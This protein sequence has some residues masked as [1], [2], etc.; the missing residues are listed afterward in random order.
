MAKELDNEAQ[1]QAAK[2]KR[3]NE[4]NSLKAAAAKKPKKTPLKYFKDARSEF[5]KVV[6]PSRKQVFNNTV[7]VLVTI[8]V[9]G[10]GI[11]ALD[12]LFKTL[13]ATMLSISL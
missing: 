6:W 2:A 11:W 13:W 12:F 4:K 9:S 10:V 7:V 3:E 5:N 1:K 8:V